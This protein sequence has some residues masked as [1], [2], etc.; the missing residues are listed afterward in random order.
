MYLDGNLHNELEEMFPGALASITEL[1]KKDPHFAKLAAAH[2]DLNLTIHRM[3][4]NEEP[5]SDET[6]EDARKKRLLLL[7]EISRSLA[8]HRQSTA[9]ACN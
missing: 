5:V 8:A 6:L 2:H 3:E 9:A 4:T 7:D 1:K